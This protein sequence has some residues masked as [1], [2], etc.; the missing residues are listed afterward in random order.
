MKIVIKT[1]TALFKL[2]AVCALVNQLSYLDYKVKELDAEI[3][4]LK[5]KFY[6]DDAKG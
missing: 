2:C 6:R 5:T 1:A 3:T 4:T